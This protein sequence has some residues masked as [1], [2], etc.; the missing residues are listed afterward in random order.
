VATHEA[1]DEVPPRKVVFE[2]VK[3]HL[4]APVPLLITY[5]TEFFFIFTIIPI[6][7]TGTYWLLT[8]F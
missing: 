3:S 2:P 6:I 4:W 8:G 7:P 5:S 1:A